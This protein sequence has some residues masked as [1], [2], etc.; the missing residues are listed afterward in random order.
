M[1]KGMLK[2]TFQFLDDPQL[3]SILIYVVLCTAPSKKKIDL[4]TALII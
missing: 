2:M 3:R 1:W 4:I